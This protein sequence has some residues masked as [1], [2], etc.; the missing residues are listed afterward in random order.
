MYFERQVGGNCRIHATNMLL[1]E[2]LYSP[3]SFS[4]LAERFATRYELPA[5]TAI[6]HD[7]IT[8]D[9]LLLPSFAAEMARDGWVS[10][11]IT[12]GTA[13]LMGY[14]PSRQ[15]AWISGLE[16]PQSPGCFVFNPGHIWSIRYSGAAG[17]SGAREC[18]LLDSLR[19]GPSPTPYPFDRPSPHMY[20]LFFTRSGTQSKLIPCLADRL[21]TLLAQPFPDPPRDLVVT[22]DRTAAFASMGDVGPVLARLVRALFGAGATDAAKEASAQIRGLYPLAKTDPFAFQR[23][24]QDSASHVLRLARSVVEAKDRGASVTFD[25]DA[26]AGASTPRSRAEL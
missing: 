13:R 24:V 19:G 17:A 9:G 26:A 25:D 7:Y 18:V 6:A 4:S 23:S 20:V 10:M 1:G 2:P 3:S 16:D 14:E 5:G 11:A 15:H 12:P 8:D 21:T 22:S